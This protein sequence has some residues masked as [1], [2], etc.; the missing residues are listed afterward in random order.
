MHKQRRYS[1]KP[2]T[3][4][5]YAYSS[6]WLTRHLYIRQLD[7]DGVALYLY[8]IRQ[9]ILAGRAAQNLTGAYIEL[10][11]MPGA[12][13]HISIKLTLVQGAADMRAVV[14]EGTDFTI[15]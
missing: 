1:A 7:H 9:N 4:S 3:A 12:G 5:V 2:S 13:Q 15:N 11:A 14:G 10:S 8:G 6:D